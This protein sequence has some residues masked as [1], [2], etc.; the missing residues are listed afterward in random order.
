MLCHFISPQQIA[1]FFQIRK[2]SFA[3]IFSSKSITS[4]IKNCS[5][6]EKNRKFAAVGF[7]LRRDT[8]KKNQAWGFFLLVNPAGCL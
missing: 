3:Q 2:R 1:T 8:C 5:L 4:I 6:G 7:F